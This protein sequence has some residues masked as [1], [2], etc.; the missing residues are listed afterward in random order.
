V[1]DGDIVA[2]HRFNQDSSKGHTRNHSGGYET[3]SIEMKDVVDPEQESPDKEDLEV[4]PETSGLRR[5]INSTDLSK[6]KDPN[7]MDPEENQLLKEMLAVSPYNGSENDF[8]SIRSPNALINSLS[9]TNGDE[10]F[11]EPQDLER[12]INLENLDL[13]VDPLS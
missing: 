8:K 5:S 2:S 12:D 4:K 1:S 10:D 7:E 9:D 13:S 6:L 3:K 11:P